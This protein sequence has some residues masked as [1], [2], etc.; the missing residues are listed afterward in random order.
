MLM[1]NQKDTTRGGLGG[2]A[3]Q[4]SSKHNEVGNKKA[5]LTN[6]YNVHKPKC[7]EDNKMED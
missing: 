4:K 3:L 5:D 1:V 2:R 7:C 6:S